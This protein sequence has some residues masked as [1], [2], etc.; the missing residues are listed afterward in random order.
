MRIEFVHLYVF[1]KKKTVGNDQIKEIKRLVTQ[2]FYA[3]IMR[4]KT[5]FIL[6]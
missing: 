4:K 1:K 6:N 3:R 2:S 5:I